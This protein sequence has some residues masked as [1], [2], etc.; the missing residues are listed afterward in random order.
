M[1]AVSASYNKWYE[2]AHVHWVV[3]QAIYYDK[4]LG[5]LRLLGVYK[6]YIYVGVGVNSKVLSCEDSSTVFDILSL[7]ES[8]YFVRV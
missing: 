7:Y 5:Q 4:L 2:R 6:P 8:G 3:V 1:T